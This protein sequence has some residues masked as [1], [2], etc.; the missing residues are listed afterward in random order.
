MKLPS[1]SPLKRGE[2]RPR[3]VEAAV[4]DGERTRRRRG[5]ICELVVVV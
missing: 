3:R 1:G 2:E 4:G 5:M